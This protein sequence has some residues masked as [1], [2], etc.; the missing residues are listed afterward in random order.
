MK[1]NVFFTILAIVALLFS[2]CIFSPPEVTTKTEKTAL[3]A[4]EQ[5]ALIKAAGP[6]ISGVEELQRMAQSVLQ[7]ET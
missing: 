1:K 7:T 4:R 2:A 6:R 3:G 5:L